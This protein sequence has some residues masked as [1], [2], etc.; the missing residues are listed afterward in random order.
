MAALSGQYPRI[1][2]TRRVIRSW[3]ASNTMVGGSHP[4]VKQ[5]VGAPERKTTGDE[6]ILAA[7]LHISSIVLAFSAN[8][9]PWTPTF[10]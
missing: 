7:R 1:L 4:T 6:V 5:T 9:F 3:C 8:K 10:R 2:A